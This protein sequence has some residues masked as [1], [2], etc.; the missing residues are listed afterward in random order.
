M[1]YTFPYLMPLAVGMAPYFVKRAR[2]VK[3][4]VTGMTV[5][6]LIGLFTVA[7]PQTHKESAEDETALLNELTSGDT[8]IVSYGER[9]PALRR[10]KV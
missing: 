2:L 6:F 7:V 9:Y 1:T 10:K 4:A 5:I 8:L 3:G